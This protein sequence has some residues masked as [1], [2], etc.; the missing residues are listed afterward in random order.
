MGYKGVKCLI[1]KASY[2]CLNSSANYVQCGGDYKLLKKKSGLDIAGKKKALN[3]FIHCIKIKSQI[4][5][6]PLKSPRSNGLCYLNTVKDRAMNTENKFLKNEKYRKEV[7]KKVCDELKQTQTPK[8]LMKEKLIEMQETVNTAEIP[9]EINDKKKQEN[10]G[11]KKEKEKMKEIKEMKKNYEKKEKKKRKDREAKKEMQ[12]KK[13]LRKLNKNMEKREKS[14]ERLE[15]WKGKTEMRLRKK[16]KKTYRKLVNK[17]QKHD[18]KIKKETEKIQKKQDKESKKAQNVQK[19]CVNSYEKCPLGYNKTN[20]HCLH[21]RKGKRTIAEANRKDKKKAARNINF[22][23]KNEIHEEEVKCKNPTCVGVNP[24]SIEGTLNKISCVCKKV[25]MKLLSNHQVCERAQWQ[26]AKNFNR[27]DFLCTCIPQ[28][29]CVTSTGEKNTKFKKPAQAFP[30]KHEEKCKCG[31]KCKKIELRDKIDQTGEPAFE[32]QVRRGGLEIFNL[33]EV[34][35]NVKNLGKTRISCTCP[36][37]NK[38]LQHSTKYVCPAGACRKA[39]NSKSISINCKCES[40]KSRFCTEK[41]CNLE[42]NL[43]PLTRSSGIIEP[44]FSLNVNT[45]RNKILNYNEIQERISKYQNVHKFCKIGRC[46]DAFNKSETDFTC[47]CRPTFDICTDETCGRCTCL[48]ELDKT[49]K[50]EPNKKESKRER[51]GKSLEHC[52]IQDMPPKK[53]GFCDFSADDCH[54][55]TWPKL[56]CIARFCCRRKKPLNSAGDGVYCCDVCQET[57]NTKQSRKRHHKKSKAKVMT[58]LEM[59]KIKEKKRIEK[60]TIDENVSLTSYCLSGLASWIIAII[61]KVFNILYTC[62]RHPK[63]SYSYAQNKLDNPKLTFL[64]IKR[65]SL[66]RYTSKKM[67]IKH[68]MARSKTAKI[69]TDEILT[70]KYVKVFL[71]KNQATHDNLILR[72]KRKMKR[73]DAAMHN[74]KHVHLLTMKKTP[75]MW[76]FYLCPRF[77]LPFLNFMMCCKKAMNVL[78]AIGTIIIWTPCLCLLNIF[79]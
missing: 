73:K 12:E 14:G 46:R 21:T 76:C 69:L 39:L 53:E 43:N 23:L 10:A 77:Y 29:K 65:W 36:S 24:S 5:N 48:K 8:K 71:P 1:V 27:E 57:N 13:M 64:T 66:S 33:E 35:Q 72:E 22:E 60:D 45:D 28:V 31:L 17:Y 40:R 26:R 34:Q 16:D 11:E 51:K 63:L 3:C 70:S 6:K 59:W 18:K 9:R 4:E 62:V 56:A 38:Y 2:P 41:T 44:L 67:R 75:Y 68:N 42:S 61:S 47:E 50:V 20:K 54:C 30:T 78:M 49:Y 7:Y 52:P 55:P 37:V 58:E 19:E 79:V 74:C 15:R 25:S 32:V